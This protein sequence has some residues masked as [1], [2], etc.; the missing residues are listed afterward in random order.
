[1]YGYLYD[2]MGFHFESKWYFQHLILQAAAAGGSQKGLH[3]C[4]DQ[5]REPIRMQHPLT[6]QPLPQDNDLG[7]MHHISITTINKRHWIFSRQKAVSIIKATKR[8]LS[9]KKP[10]VGGSYG[11]SRLLAAF[12]RRTASNTWAAA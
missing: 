9:S 6:S 5:Y 3:G 8:R 4:W 1:M 10:Q 7:L 2:I 11:Y 12:I